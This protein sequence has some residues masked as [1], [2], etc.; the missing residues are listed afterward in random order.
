ML[1]TGCRPNSS[2]NGPRI[3]PPPIPNKPAIRPDKKEY[4]G[5]LTNIIGASHLMSV[6]L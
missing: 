4:S 2:S 6:L 3:R 5:N 1:T